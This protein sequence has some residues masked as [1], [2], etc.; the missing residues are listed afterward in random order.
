MMYRECCDR[1]AGKF[2]PVFFFI[3]LLIPGPFAPA[4]QNDRPL[5]KLNV[6][7][8]PLSVDLRKATS[9]APVIKKVAPSVVNI[10]TTTT[11]KDV[12]SVHP[13]FN[14]PLFK[15][16]FGGDGGS[17]RRRPRTEQSLGSGVIVSSDGYV[18]TASHVV[19]GADRVK[20]S[21]S[22]GDQEYDAKVVGT[23][24]PTDVAVLKLDMEKALPAVT[25]GD[26]E[27]LEVGDVV[28]ALGNPFGVGQTVTMGIISAVGR[29]G[30]GIAGYENFIQ[31]DAA[32]NPGNSGG[33]L[34]DAAG[35]VVGI[36]TAI[37]SGTGGFM[38]VGFAVP[39]NMARYVMERLVTEGKVNRGYLGI[40]IRPLPSGMAKAYDLTN[41]G[42]GVLVFGVTRGSGAEKAGLKAG[43]VIVEL[44]GKKVADPRILQLMVAQ[45]APGAN[46][47]VRILRGQSGEKPLEKNLTVALGT[48]P[49]NAFARAGAG[50]LEDADSPTNDALDGV[51]VADLDARARR[52]FEVPDKI[53]GALVVN[54]EP[55]SNSAE[56]GLRPGDVL[57]QI[58]QKPVQ[59]AKEAVELSE[60][61]N[62][63]TIRL[64]IWSRASGRLGGTRDIL[65]E[66]KKQE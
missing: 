25:L 62:G 8:K 31:T 40:S 5:P 6:D 20:V 57:I 2:F 27:K 39:I 50:D 21:L 60:K 42:G 28:L 36:N 35:R 4:Q 19:D 58:D 63:D 55:H 54:V 9:F 49:Q 22:T 16:F 38:G 44:N 12:R 23:D 52:Q 15:R 41:D 13:F 51:E 45:T 43:D 17:Q 34:V 3:S 46:A 47:N 26:S 65:V 66:N 61:A 64:R 33:A 30:F 10:Y 59:N 56:A 48:L 32:I 24:P 29:G 1:F 37:V 11:V 18:L 14:D 53:K 7:E